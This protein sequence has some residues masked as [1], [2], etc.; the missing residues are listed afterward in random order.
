[1]NK[2]LKILLVSF[3]GAIIASSC[4]EIQSYPETPEVDYKSF[5]LFRTTDAL[6]NEILLGRLEFEFTDGDGNVGDSI[7]ASESD[8]KYNL[9]LSLYDYV[10]NDFEKI[11]DISS[12]NFRIPYIERKGQN[13]TLKGTITV[14]LE[15]KKI[16]Y[17]T[18]FYTFYIKDRDQNQSNTDT[19][20][21]IDLANIS[22]EEEP[23][24]DSDGL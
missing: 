17:D 24:A 4:E 15:Y 8:V 20:D 9:F 1:M 14:D 7:P 23:E 13:K 3:G 19:T 12:L 16:E 22:F 18:I 6:G 2:I 5:S 10:D 21:I 11:E